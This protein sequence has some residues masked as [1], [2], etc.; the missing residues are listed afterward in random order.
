MALDTDSPC[1][2]C[3]SGPAA[4]LP[5]QAP[6]HHSSRGT[7]AAPP[8]TAPY[9]LV[10]LRAT[11]APLAQRPSLQTAGFLCLRRAVPPG[12]FPGLPSPGHPSPRCLP[13]PCRVGQESSRAGKPTQESRKESLLGR[14][15]GSDIR[16]GGDWGRR[17]EGHV[18]GAGKASCPR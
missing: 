1:P 17:E 16:G 4:P 15:R 13:T 8:P 18:G 6:S 5:S 2:C 12:V 7:R 11:A 10:A 9:S 3:A 14:S